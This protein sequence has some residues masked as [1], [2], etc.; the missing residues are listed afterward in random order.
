MPFQGLR[1]GRDQHVLESSNHSLCLAKLLSSI[2]SQHTTHNLSNTQQ[3]NTTQHNT[4]NTHNTQTHTHQ[5]ILTNPP[6][7]RPTQHHSPLLPLLSLFLLHEPLNQERAVN[8]SILA[9]GTEHG[10]NHADPCEVE[11][12]KKSEASARRPRGWHPC[13]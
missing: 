5:H 2:L 9:N 4:H 13:R 1:T 11:R 12:K 8:L 6:T 3:H 7:H 10:L